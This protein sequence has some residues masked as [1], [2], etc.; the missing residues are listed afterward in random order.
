MIQTQNSFTQPICRLDSIMSEFINENEESLSCQPLTNPYTLNCINWTQESCY[1]GNQD[2]IS[3]HH[4]NL[5]KLQVLKVL[6]IFWQVITSLKLNLSMNVIQ[7]HKL[8]ILFHF[9]IKKWLWY[10]YQI[11]FIFWSQHWILYQYTMKLNH[12][13]L[14]I[15][16]HWW[17]QCVNFNF[18][19]LDSIF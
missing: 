3:A 13:Y 11:F 18:F 5:T 7:I 12:Q 2:S 15:T 17:G 8:I 6:L 4:L 10:L 16:L 1:F 19:G 9:L 14:M